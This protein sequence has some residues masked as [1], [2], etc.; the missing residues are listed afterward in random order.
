VQILK[1]LINIKATEPVHLPVYKGG[2]V[3]SGFGLAF[4]KVCC[5]F[6]NRNCNQCILRPNCVWSYVFDT[7]RPQTAAVLNKAE[8]VPHPFVIE[9][10]DDETTVLIKGDCLNFNLILIGRAADYLPYFI[11]AFEQMAEQGLGRPRKPFRLI[12]VYQDKRLIYD[13]KQAAL[14][15]QA[16]P[17]VLN[18]APVNETARQIKIKLITPTRII[19]QG[20]LCRRPGFGNIIRALLRR[21]WLLSYFHDQVMDIDYQGLITSAEKVE[22]K[23][24]VFAGANWEH[25]SRRQN[26]VIEYEGITGWAIYTGELGQFLPILRAGEI[27]HIG[28][29]TTF[30]MG[31]YEMEVQ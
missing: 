21:I 30:G 25:F 9:P 8:T 15:E 12:G 10:P 31:R 7:P 1:L 27:L 16:M 26:R 3:R 22:L 24:A 23:E 2:A 20:R 6:V 28:K 19:N 18:L 11:Y 17:M 29:G 5:P 14:I 13:P 4:R